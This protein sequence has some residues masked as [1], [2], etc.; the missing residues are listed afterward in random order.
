MIINQKT[1]PHIEPSQ[2][3]VYSLETYTPIFH[4]KMEK[5]RIKPRTI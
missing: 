1:E 2:M 3:V 4:K 5:K